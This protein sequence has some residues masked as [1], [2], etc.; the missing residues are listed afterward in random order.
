[1]H[2]IF[3]ILAA[4][5]TAAIGQ[6]LLKMGMAGVGHIDGIYLEKVIQMF[7]NPTVVV[8]LIVF[9][10]STMFWLT[11]LSRKDLSY[12]YP[13]IGINMVLVFLLSAVILHEE[14]GIY[15]IIGMA[16][17]VLGAVVVSQT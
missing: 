1:V 7:T 15:R 17:I 4:S 9:G 6:L 13:F 8:G 11:A 14:L 10:I 2:V 3:V 16:V 5:I 12:V